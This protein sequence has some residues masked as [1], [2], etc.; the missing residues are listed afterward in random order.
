MIARCIR[1]H[2]QQVTIGFI[3]INHSKT[4]SLKFYYF[5]VKVFRWEE[6]ETKRAFYLLPPG[7]FNHFG[8][9]FPPDELPPPRTFCFPLSWAG[10]VLSKVGGGGRFCASSSI[11]GNSGGR[12]VEPIDLSAYG[13]REGVGSTNYWGKHLQKSGEEWRRVIVAIEQGLVVWPLGQI[14]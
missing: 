10:G 7:N 3:Q 1:D 11:V 8:I 4:D 14:L 9:A 2:T 13:K 5:S 12:F 6:I